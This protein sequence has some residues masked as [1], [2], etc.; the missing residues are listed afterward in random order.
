RWYFGFDDSKKA[1]Q[2]AGLARTE[3]L[4]F[5]ADS[6]TGTIVVSNASPEQLRSIDELIRLWDVPEPVNKRRVRYT[7]LVSL[8]YGKASP[9]AETIKETYRDLLSSNDKAFSPGPG[10]R[11]GDSAGPQKNDSPRG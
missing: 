1:A 4:R 11:G 10:G 7:R 8:R 9:I 2:P 5:I 6:E 3:K